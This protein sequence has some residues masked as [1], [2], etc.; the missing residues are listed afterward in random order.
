VPEEGNVG[1]FDRGL[2]LARTSLRVVAADPIILLVLLAGLVGMVAVSGSLYLVVFHHLPTSHDLTFPHELVALPVLWF[3]TIA[4]SYCAVVV[5]VMADRRLRG[6]APRVSDG[7]AVAN[8][9]LGRILAWTLLSIA[10]GLVLQVIAERIKLGWLVSRLLGFAWGLATT[11]VMPVLALEN[12]S[13]HDSIRR[14][15]AVFRARWG[16]YVVANGSIIGVGFLVAMVP[17]AAVTVAVGVFSV[18]AAV[19]VGVV[20]VGARILLSTALDSIVD[21]ALYRYA[22]DGTT[23]GGFLAADLEGSFRPKR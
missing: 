12:L 14:S 3:G 4:S 23:V 13:L 20:L 18:P 11:F 1:R 19:A 22:V 21:V 2:R 6:E 5:A 17:V 15:A 9:R 16:E 10:V 7:I 8:A